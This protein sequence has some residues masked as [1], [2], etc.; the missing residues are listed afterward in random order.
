[1]VFHGI[2]QS[3]RSLGGQRVR[4]YRRVNS[5]NPHIQWITQAIDTPS[6]YTGVSSSTP[7]DTNTQATE[8]QDSVNVR[9]VFEWSSSDQF[10][11]L[12]TYPRELPLVLRSP[13]ERSCH[14]KY[15]TTELGSSPN[16]PNDDFYWFGLSSDDVE[17]KE[18]YVDGEQWDHHEMEHQGKGRDQEDQD[19]DRCHRMKQAE[20][21]KDEGKLGQEKWKEQEETENDESS[22]EG[23]NS[24][25]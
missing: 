4:D 19:Q 18:I 5:V 2:I 21:R 13:S 11:V 22:K 8:T 16:S 14:S 23:S 10:D 6:N 20:E 1:M 12:N 9:R 25:V 24:G 17:H 3:S 7:D 15:D